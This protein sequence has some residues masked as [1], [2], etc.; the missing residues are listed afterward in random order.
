MILFIRKFSSIFANVLIRLICRYLGMSLLVSFPAWLLVLLSLSSI[1]DG[2]R[3]ILRQPLYSADVDLGSRL[4]AHWRMSVVIP[5]YRGAF[6]LSILLMASRIS[7]GHQMTVFDRKMCC[8]HKLLDNFLTFPT[9][10]GAPFWSLS[11]APQPDDWQIDW[12]FQCHFAQGPG[13][14]VFVRIGGSGVR[15]FFLDL[16]GLQMVWSWRLSE[17]MYGVKVALF[18]SVVLLEVCYLRCWRD[19]YLPV[20]GFFVSLLELYVFALPVV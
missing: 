11:P 10:L 2:K 19:V 18:K 20:F 14:L 7:F 5:S 4:K 8:K 9:R 12:L 17:V 1:A 3:A 13:G 15:G 6:V 16:I